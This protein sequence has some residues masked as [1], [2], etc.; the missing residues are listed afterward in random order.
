MSYLDKKS[1]RDID[2]TGKK[3]IVRVD[4]NVPMKDGKITDDT[5]I[6]A[7][8][9]TIHYLLEQHAAVILMS[10]LGRPKGEPKA[11]FSLKPVADR[12]DILL[13]QSVF[14]APDCVGAEVEKMALELRPGQVL[15]LENL[16]FH[17]EEEKNAQDFAA[18]LAGLAD[19][20][21]NDAFGTAHRA[22]ASTA[23]I[24]A[25]LPAVAGFLIEKEIKSLGRAVENPAHPYTAI[26]GG[27]KVSDKILVIE[28][29]LQKVDR[30]LIGGGMANTFLAAQGKDMQASLVEKDR[31][32]WAQELLHSP[33]ADKLMLPVD[34]IAAEVFDADAAHQ[35]CGVDEI[36]A[37][38]MALD[39]G[40]QTRQRFADAVSD[41]ETIVWN[42]PLGVFEMDAFAAGTLEMAHAVAASNAFSVVGGGDSVSAVHKAG[43]AE[44]ISH[45]STGGGA[46]LEF[47]E[48]KILP[49]IAAL[50]DR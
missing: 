11:E 42:G 41:A 26:I 49:G 44:Q 20:Y 22:H 5:R 8:L 21:V 12:L 24:A 2:F 38:W 37:G 45:I 36:P 16:R 33:A 28:N 4:F 48:G 25:Y 1:I 47:L 15:L 50:N 7:A 14:F 13:N 29:L 34:V 43:V 32:A 18:A 19:V 35:A 46:S 23:G 17:A 10:H 31:L 39:I 9:P 27:A 30:L 6:R 40:P 3:A